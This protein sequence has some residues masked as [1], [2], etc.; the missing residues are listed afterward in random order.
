M[1]KGTVFAKRCCL[2]EKKCWQQ[3]KKVLVLRGTFSGTTCVYLPTKFQVSCVILAIFKGGNFIPL[4]T[5]QNEPQKSSLRLKLNNFLFIIFEKKSNAQSQLEKVENKEIQFRI[6]IQ[7]LFTIQIQE[8]ENLGSFLFYTI[9]STS[10]NTTWA[11]AASQ[12]VLERSPTGQQNIFR[13][14]CKRSPVFFETL[15]CAM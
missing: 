2:L 4:P 12:K 11:D 1:S 13:G 3:N 6:Q 15:P 14:L 10:K 7:L 5:V 9:D 8:R